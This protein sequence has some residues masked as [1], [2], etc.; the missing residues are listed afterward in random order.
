MSAETDEV[1]SSLTGGNK[2]TV[3]VII[4]S[5]LV[6]FLVG[7]IFWA[8]AT[9]DQ[10]VQIQ[11][12]LQKIETQLTRIGDINSIEQRGTDNERR[13]ERLEEENRHRP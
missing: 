4:G 8:G 2:A 10:V 6:A 5:G 7:A 12:R 1:L 13:I 3:R 9:Y 11:S